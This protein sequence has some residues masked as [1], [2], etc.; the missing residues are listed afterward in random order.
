[1]NTNAKN[2][3]GI[4]DSGVGG[5]TVANAIY[6]ALP[7]ENIIYYGDTVHLPYGDKSPAAIQGYSIKIADFLLAQNCKVIVIACNS[8][9]S[10]AYETLKEHIG[11]KALLVNVIDPVVDYVADKNFKQVGII[12]TRATIL[13]NIYHN[14]ITAKSPERRTVSKATPLLASFVEE[15]FFRKRALT[16]MLLEEYLADEDLQN[17]D[18]LIL[19]CTHYPL[20]KDDIDAYYRQKVTLIDSTKIVADYVEQLLA[21]NGL[22]NESNNSLNFYVSDYTDSFEKMVNI[23]FGSPVNLELKRL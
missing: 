11:D 16:E 4:F 15:G 8:A 6:G 22:L 23:F 5:L 2:P 20:L 18:A 3:I 19:A 13:S 1:L 14:K 12:G 17:I 7:N 21:E 10:H 9:S